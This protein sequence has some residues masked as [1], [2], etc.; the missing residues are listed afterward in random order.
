MK[1]GPTLKGCTIRPRRV[2]ARIRAIA[3]EVLP[4]PLWVPATTTV[5]IMMGIRNRMR[6]AL[7]GWVARCE[8]NS[9]HTSFTV[10]GFCAAIQLTS[11]RWNHAWSIHWGRSS[12]KRNEVC[13]RPG[14]YLD[15]FN[16]LDRLMWIGC[17]EPALNSS[18]NRLTQDDSIEKLGH[19]SH[20][21]THLESP[22]GNIDSVDILEAT[23]IVFENKI[24]CRFF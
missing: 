24:N 1:S 2:Q 5:G 6:I 8:T 21:E 22:L 19:Q 14:S 16:K 20:P 4:T 15:R 18:A 23:H 9:I 10:V 3:T 7:V 11:Y 17:I 12:L 13:D